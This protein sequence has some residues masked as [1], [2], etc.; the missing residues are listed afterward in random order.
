MLERRFVLLAHGSKDTRWQLPFKE[1]TT[2]LKERLGADTVRLAY[3]EF[4]P[5]ALSD[6]A[7]EAIKDGKRELLVLPLF[8]AAGAHL[9]EDIPAQVADARTR[10]P[11]LQIELLPPIGEHPRV[12]ALFQEIVCEYA[13]A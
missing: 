11:Q 13:R 1:L 9:A 8:L 5:P 3:M 4:T 12:K 10:F 6:V 2:A 7:E